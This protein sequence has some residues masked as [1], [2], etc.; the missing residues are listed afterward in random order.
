LTAPAARKSLQF[1]E[2]AGTSGS[3]FSDQLSAFLA[4]IAAFVHLGKKLKAES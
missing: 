1:R 4:K 2:I 3:A